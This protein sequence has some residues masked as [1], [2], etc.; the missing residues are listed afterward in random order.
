V[1]ALAQREPAA[2]K[3]AHQLAERRVS[4]A[5]THLVEAAGIPADRLVR[6]PDSPA[7]AAP[8]EG[9]VEFSLEPAS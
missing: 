5:R 6:D 1:N 8:G 3:A 2:S 7:I 9:R 4:V